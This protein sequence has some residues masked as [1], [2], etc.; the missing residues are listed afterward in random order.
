[1]FDAG[2]EKHQGAENSAL[3]NNAPLSLT[4]LRISENASIRFFERPAS[5]PGRSAKQS[6]QA[7]V[8]AIHRDAQA[9]LLY[10]VPSTIVDQG[11]R[12]HESQNHFPL[13]NFQLRGIPGHV[14][15]RHRIHRQLRRSEI[16]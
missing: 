4:P 5:F 6:A 7:N 8:R 13:W 14:F 3:K 9:W 10:P 2:D 1:M 12:K 15:V 16:D 11:A